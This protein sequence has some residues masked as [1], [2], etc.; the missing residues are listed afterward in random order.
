NRDAPIFEEL[1]A[2]VAKTSA[3]PDRL[4]A[5]L[6]PLAP[7]IYFAVLYGSVAK[8]SDHAT[9]DLDVLLVADDLPLEQIY[10]A[11]EPIEA[12]LGRRVSPTVYLPDE[13]HRRRRARQ[14]FL[15]K[16][17]AGPHVILLGR[18]DAIPAR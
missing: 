1:R 14:P 5:A 3:I 12:P 11:V 7:R 9:S 6:S 4:A 13:F 16:V 10:T 18:E 8:R 2:I 15:T 17:L